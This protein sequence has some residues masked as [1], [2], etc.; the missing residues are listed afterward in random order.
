MIGESRE[1]TSRLEIVTSCE[2][3]DADQ[4]DPEYAEVNYFLLGLK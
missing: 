4:K 1:L 3:D 2:R